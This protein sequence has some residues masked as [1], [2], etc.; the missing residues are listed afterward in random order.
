MHAWRRRRSPAAASGQQ[1]AVGG[2]QDEFYKVNIKST[3]PLCHWTWADML[4]AGRQVLRCRRSASQCFRQFN[5]GR[6]HAAAASLRHGL[7][8]P[9]GGV[10]ASCL[11]DTLQCVPSLPPL[12][13]V[14][15]YSHRGLAKPLMSHPL[16][17]QPCAARQAP[18]G[19]ER[20]AAAAS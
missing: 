17:P 10:L 18:G 4:T 2:W 8:P 19:A 15:C 13:C 16:N 14:F 12:F 3:S 20:R 9:D 7:L 6:R 11:N 1:L 5:R